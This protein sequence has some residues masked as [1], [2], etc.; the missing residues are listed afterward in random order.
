MHATLASLR[1]GLRTL[2]P[3]EYTG[4]E[5]NICRKM[6]EHSFLGPFLAFLFL[7]MTTY[8]ILLCLSSESKEEMDAISIINSEGPEKIRVPCCFKDVVPSYHSV[9]L[10]Q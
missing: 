10:G 3:P 2:V 8:N 6:K 5:E 9:H 1:P 4:M 7:M